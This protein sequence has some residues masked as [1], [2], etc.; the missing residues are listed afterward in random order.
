MRDMRNNVHAAVRAAFAVVLGATAG[1]FGA[2]NAP[3]FAQNC[4]G[5]PHALGTSRV[6][7]LAPGE[8]TR[9]GLMQYPQTLPLADKEVVLTFDDGPRPPFSDK[10]LDIL[11]EQCVWATYFLV[12]EMARTYPATVRR[13]Y[14]AGHTIGTHS[15]DHPTHFEK[16]PIEKA[17]QEIDQGIADVGAALGDPNDLAPFFRIPGLA[18]SD[19]V[20]Q[21]LAARSLVVFSSD[22]VADDWYR[23][24]GPGEIVRRAMRRL[25]ARGKGILLLHDIH[26]GTVLALPMLL[27]RLKAEGFHVVHVVPAITKPIEVA[28]DHGRPAAPPGGP[29]ASAGDGGEPSVH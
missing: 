20:E 14:E 28:G 11:A 17:R 9:V 10:V 27:E 21:E 23:R 5:N 19:E 8:L 7:E 16:L 18:R 3:A 2:L 6:L 29:E 22:T 26:P 25:E 1:L 12:G 13:I 15:E 24:I 4:R